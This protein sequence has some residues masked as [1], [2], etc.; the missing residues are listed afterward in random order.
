MTINVC[1]RSY[2]RNE[3]TGRPT[4]IHYPIGSIPRTSDRTIFCFRNVFPFSFTISRIDFSFVRRRSS[5]FRRQRPTTRSVHRNAR[6]R[7]TLA[8]A[9][10]FVRET[11]ERPVPRARSHATVRDG[12]TRS[13]SSPIFRL[14][15][16]GEF[17]AGA[18]CPPDMAVVDVLKSPGSFACLRE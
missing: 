10:L 1:T 2:S 3:F 4:G 18:K 17:S 12:T 8:P 13:Y 14:V 7:S 11:I 16:V 15:V 9:I 6:Y 5:I